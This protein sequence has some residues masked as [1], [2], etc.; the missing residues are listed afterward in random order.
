MPVLTFA[1]FSNILQ[2]KHQ[3][4]GLKRLYSLL[5]VKK[6]MSNCDEKDSEYASQNV[7]SILR[8]I[9]VEVTIYKHELKT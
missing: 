6:K 9:Y 3:N 2:V 1:T 8:H 5:E 4:S 7:I